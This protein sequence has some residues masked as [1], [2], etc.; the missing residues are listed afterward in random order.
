MCV[1]K[2]EEPATILQTVRMMADET[3]GYCVGQA[4][5]DRKRRGVFEGMDRLMRLM[6]V[7]GLI[8]ID[9][10]D[11]LPPCGSEEWSH[12]VYSLV[13]RPSLTLTRGMCVM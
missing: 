2:L 6:L 13:P 11:A 3:F 1:D 5:G 9:G 12:T 4:H 7:L 8:R 10:G